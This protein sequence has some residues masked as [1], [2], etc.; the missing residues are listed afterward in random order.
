MNFKNII[1]NCCCRQSAQSIADMSTNNHA[2][3][4]DYIFL[5][6]KNYVGEKEHMVFFEYKEVFDM[7]IYNSMTGKKE[8]FIP[9]DGNNVSCQFCEY[10]DICYKKEKDLVYINR[11]NE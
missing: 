5:D 6:Y 11:N 4:R 10:R 7:K 2:Y 3:N 8:E 9:I 1:V